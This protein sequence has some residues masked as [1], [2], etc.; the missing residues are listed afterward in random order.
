MFHQTACIS[1]DSRWKWATLGVGGD[2][3]VR[4]RKE[5]MKERTYLNI[6][7]HTLR[8]TPLTHHNSSSLLTNPDRLSAFIYS[9]FATRKVFM[10]AG[11][12]YISDIHLS[13]QSRQLQ[14]GK[15]KNAKRSSLFFFSFHLTFIYIM[16]AGGWYLCENNSLKWISSWYLFPFTEQQKCTLLL[17][18]PRFPEVWN[19]YCVLFKDARGKLLFLRYWNFFNNCIT[20]RPLVCAVH[21]K[22]TNGLAAELHKS[23]AGKLA[24]ARQNWQGIW[25][26]NEGIHHRLLRLLRLK[27]RL[28]RAAA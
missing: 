15:E 4:Q 20:A 19:E 11:T 8:Q 17:T 27:R 10:R 16:I 22:W 3:A 21:W 6:S 14:F 28:S 23:M 9:P 5:E 24:K 1:Q 12:V 13:A 25:L 26:Y 7:V 2:G 18:Q